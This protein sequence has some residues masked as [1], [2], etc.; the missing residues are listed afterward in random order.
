M[1]SNLIRHLH[2]DLDELRTLV[3]CR[4]VLTESGGKDSFRIL[5]QLKNNFGV[6]FQPSCLPALPNHKVALTLSN[7]HY[8]HLT[9]RPS[10]LVNGALLAVR[11][12]E[13]RSL[14]WRGSR[15]RA[16]VL[17]QTRDSLKCGN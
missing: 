11:D 6:I 16:R 12:S 2:T 8:D 10:L 4:K 5:E 7:K 13:E 15:D 1:R 9:L 14:C 17:T 3:A